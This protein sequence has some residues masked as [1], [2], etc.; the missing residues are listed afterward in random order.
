MITQF[1]EKCMNKRKNSDENHIPP[2]FHPSLL[3]FSFFPACDHYIIDG[4]DNLPDHGKN[5]EHQQEAGNAEYDIPQFHRAFT[6]DHLA[7]PD[8]KGHAQDK[9]KHIEERDHEHMVF[10]GHF[11]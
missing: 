10:A 5:R 6:G 4:Q 8:G 3:S 1:Y 9:G 11:K 2:E 7:N